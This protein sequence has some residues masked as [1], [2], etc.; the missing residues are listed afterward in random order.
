VDATQD[1]PAAAIRTAVG[2]ISVCARAAWPIIPEAA[3][4]A[5]AA[6]G[7]SETVPV[8]PTTDHLAV[9]AGRRIVHPG[10]LF[11]KLGAEWAETQ[12]RRFACGMT[13]R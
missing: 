10:P 7:E 5:L 11:V 8:F 6:I 3:A 4:K 12:S 9:P 2:L 13:L 1:R